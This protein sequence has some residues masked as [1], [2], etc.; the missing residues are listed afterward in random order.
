M[1]AFGFLV[2]AAILLLALTLW[3]RRSPGSLRL[4]DAY[5]RLNRSVGL[6]VESG[7]RLHISLGRGNLFSTR[8][9]PLLLRQGMHRSPFFHRIH[10][11]LVIAPRE[12]KINIASRPDV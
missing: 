2:L 3:R 6:A 9:V 8:V 4:I 7:T 12:Q 1:V 5:E 10:Y 11:S